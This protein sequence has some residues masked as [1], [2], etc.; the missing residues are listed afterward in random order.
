MVDLLRYPIVTSPNP[1]GYAFQ[2][3][4]EKPGQPLM[5]DCLL[6]YPFHP[7]NKLAT[8][9]SAVTR[10]VYSVHLIGAKHGSLFTPVLITRLRYRLTQAILLPVLITRLR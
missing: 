5:K 4:V 7:S 1:E 6:P 9:Y 10:M 8:I 2:W 3:I